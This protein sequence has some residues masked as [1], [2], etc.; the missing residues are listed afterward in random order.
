MQTPGTAGR[1]ASPTARGC[2]AAGVAKP[3][4]GPR[5]L[6]EPT[7]FSFTLALQGLCQAVLTVPVLQ[8]KS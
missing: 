7:Y 3:D 4:S 8:I 6:H 2:L 5:V 1:P